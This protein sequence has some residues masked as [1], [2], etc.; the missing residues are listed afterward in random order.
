MEIKE[1]K[2]KSF[3][4]KPEGTLGM[5]TLAG[6]VVAGGYFLYTSIET[7]IALAQDTLY[8]SGMLIGLSAII[9]MVLDP[10]CE[11]WWVLPTKAS[12]GG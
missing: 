6:L 3:W 10:K 8:L 9:Y 2:P 1:F 7:I 5:V 4:E 12:C 11:I